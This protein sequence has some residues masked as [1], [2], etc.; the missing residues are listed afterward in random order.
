MKDADNR[1]KMSRRNRSIQFGVLSAFLALAPA[2]PAQLNGRT[3]T[4]RNLYQGVE[5]PGYTVTF[6]VDSTPGAL[7]VT[8][9][10][11]QGTGAQFS[12]DVFDVG[13]NQASVVITSLSSGGMGASPNLLHFTD[14]AQTIAPF[15]G[16]TLGAV[17]FP[18]VEAS[19]VAFDA[20]TFTLD[21]GGLT[22]VPGYSARLD[23]DGTGHEASRLTIQVSEV[24]L[25]WNS[26]SN[27]MYQV[28]YRSE[29]TTNQWTNLGPPVAGNGTGNWITDPV[30]APR[31]FYQVVEL[32]Q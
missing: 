12:I 26:V 4:L 15:T 13:S 5:Q 17:S 6:T 9:W 32:P 14:E 7:E 3:L 19:R 28:Q 11:A 20:D 1:S 24:R 8:N 22:A 29:L 10:G 31:R 2:V 18:G 23:I 25:C 27:A 21:L 30:R 16:A